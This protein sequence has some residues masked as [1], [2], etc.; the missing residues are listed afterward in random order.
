MKRLLTTCY[1]L[2]IGI[3]LLAQT[4]VEM[5]RLGKTNFGELTMDRIKPLD[6]LILLASGNDPLIDAFNTSQDKT[7]Q[8]IEI[9]KKKWLQHLSFTAGAGYGT[10]INSDQLVTSGINDTNLT[11][12]TRQSAYYNVGLNIRLPFTEIS[13]RKNEIRI[14]ELEI[15]RVEHLKRNEFEEMKDNVI[16]TYSD[17]K[18]ALKT[19]ELQSEVVETNDV[20]MEIAESYFKAGKLP[21]EQYRM[22]VDKSYTAKLELEKAKNEAW[23][24]FRVLN[25]LVG[26]SILK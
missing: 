17:L 20:A 10:G 18:Y 15:E 5:S 19:I 7:K 16:T 22:A 25:E 4:Q 3:N 8:E 2:I 1:L 23:F 12:Y 26:Q 9:T 13:S 6:E 11:Y 14:K 21:I 24:S